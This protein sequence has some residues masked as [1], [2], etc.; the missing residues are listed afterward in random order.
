MICSSSC[1]ILSQP[2]NIR[3]PNTL[4]SQ[5]DFASCLL[6]QKQ[7]HVRPSV[8]SLFLFSASNCCVA[9][10]MIIETLE[11]QRCSLSNILLQVSGGENSLAFHS[12]LLEDGNGRS[13]FSCLNRSEGRGWG[14]APITQLCVGCWRSV[15]SNDE[16]DPIESCLVLKICPVPNSNFIRIYF[17]LSGS[18]AIIII[19]HL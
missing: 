7:L 10:V 5:L 18:F 9:V 17:R 15:L 13:L 19:R 2:E 14:E 11:G 3:F 1:Y 16:L 8:T 12:A 4:G 6:K